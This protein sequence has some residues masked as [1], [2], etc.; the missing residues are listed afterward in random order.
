M[1]I[2][3]GAAF[4]DF[5]NGVV[6]AGVP[7]VA[8]GTVLSQGYRD[9]AISSFPVRVGY[10]VAPLTSVFMEMSGNRRD[11]HVSQF[12]S[13]GYRVV[14]GMLYEPGPGARIKGEFFAGYMNQNYTGPG[15]DTVST[16]TVGSA[17][18]FLLTPTVTA[19]L[20]TR[21]SAAEAS[22]SGGQFATIP[23]DG[24]S[25]IETVAT[26]RLDWLAA[27]KTVLGIGLAYLE[28]DFLAANRTD[29]SWSPLASA[30]YFVNPYLTLG[31]DYRHLNFGSSGFLVS[32]YSRNVF[33]L[34][35][36]MRM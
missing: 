6:G 30:K 26:G 17:L 12:D 15:F 3:A 36:N 24:V 14:G 29:R 25:V 16:W 9:G 8:A 19:T 22:L 21:R 31:F 4:V 23:G 10:V 13:R 11:F 35:A 5:N 34:S 7:G 33:L 32:S 27:P 28:D 1:S 18:A 2:G 20:E